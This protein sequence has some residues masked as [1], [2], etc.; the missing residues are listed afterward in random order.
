[1]AVAQGLG[2]GEMGSYC[3]MGT[4]FQLAFKMKKVPWMDCGKLHNMRR[5]LML[6]NCTLQDD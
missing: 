2:K 1:M 3:V 5:Y 4:E 6:L